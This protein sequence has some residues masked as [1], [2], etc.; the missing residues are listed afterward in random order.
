LPV[1]KLNSITEIK[2]ENTK[3]HY[4]EICDFGFKG[5]GVRT[6]VDIPRGSYVLYYSGQVKAGD[7]ETDDTYVYQTRKGRG[8]TNMIDATK[9]DGDYGRGGIRD[10]NSSN[11]PFAQN[12]NG[13]IKTSTCEMHFCKKNKKHLVSMVIKSHNIM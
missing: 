11:L 10:F 6:K 7:I 13:Q 8:G 12:Q 5:R 9:E 2:Q 3:P 1:W 4:L